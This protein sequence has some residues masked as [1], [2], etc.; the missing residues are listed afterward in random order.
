LSVRLQRTGAPPCIGRSIP[1]DAQL[2]IRSVL[3][4]DRPSAMLLGTLWQTVVFS[5]TQEL[6]MSSFWGWSQ[7]DMFISGSTSYDAAHSTTEVV[8]MSIRR[9]LI[10]PFDLL[11]SGQAGLCAWMRS[12]P[13]TPE[14]STKSP[15]ECWQ[16]LCHTWLP[17]EYLLAQHATDSE[18]RYSD[19]RDGEEFY[20][21]THIGRNFYCG[22][23]YTGNCRGSVLNSQE[24][25]IGESW[26]HRL[27]LLTCC[28]SF[29]FET[30]LF[31]CVSYHF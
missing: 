3:I 2:Y 8:A 27:V 10:A 11:R 29:V 30:N 17:Y 14:S 26:L 20:K 5:L 21:K 23:V 28:P 25:L 12:F 1:K 16:S 24:I 22:G 9:A 31:F 18:S 7:L 4:D 13:Y 15:R 19:S 6:D